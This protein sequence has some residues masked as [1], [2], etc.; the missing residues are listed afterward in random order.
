[1]ARRKNAA[2]E[3]TCHSG[4]SKKVQSWIVTAQG[5]GRRVPASC[6][7]ARGGP[8]TP[9]ER[10]SEREPDL[11]VGAAGPGATPAPR[12]ARAAPAG[13]VGASVPRRPAGA[14]SVSSTSSRAARPRAKRHGV[15]AGAA[16]PLGHGRD[17]ERQVERPRSPQ[18]P[19]QLDVWRAAAAPGPAP[20]RTSAPRRPRSARTASSVRTA[21]SPAA[22]SSTSSGSTMR[23]GG[24]AGCAEVVHARHLV[25]HHGR[26]AHA[27]GLQRRQA[28]ALGERHIGEGPGPPVQPGQHGSG[29]APGE[30]DTGRP[31]GPRRAAG[32]PPGR[33][34]D[35]QRPRAR[36][37]SR[38]RGRRRARAGPRSYGLERAHGE[39]ELPGDAQAAARRASVA[40]GIRA[41]AGGRRR[42]RPRSRPVRPVDARRRPGRPPRAGTGRRSGGVDRAA[43]RSAA[44]CQRRPAP[45]RRLGVPAPGHVVHRHDQPARAGPPR[46]RGAASETECTTS[47]PAGA[48]NSPWSQARVRSG[49][50]AAT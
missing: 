47:K 31:P 27:H 12:R 22:M 3:R 37:A 30:D 46:E 49:P 29:T 35:H 26:G 9:S 5:T 16:R 24:G 6:S 20:T 15:V 32:A 13:Q 39:E 40:G 45:R 21:P 10:S 44:S 28:V 19:P 17:V 14:T 1:M 8:P 50:G 38:A 36:G 43:R 48:R 33:P 23:A 18:R 34:D 7:A 11:L 2:L 42:R 25:G 4:W 41:R